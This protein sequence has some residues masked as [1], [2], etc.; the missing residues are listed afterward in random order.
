MIKRI[1]SLIL[2][3]VLSLFVT[4]FCDAREDM[5]YQKTDFPIGDANGDGVATDT[6]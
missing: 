3:I 1:I 4:V 5:Q 2:V 6:E